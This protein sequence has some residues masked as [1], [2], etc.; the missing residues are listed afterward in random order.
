MEDN[1]KQQRVPEAKK[2]TVK[3]SKQNQPAG[4]AQEKDWLEQLLGTTEQDGIKNIYKFL[5]HPMALVAVLVFILLW[6]L[7]EKKTNSGFSK[8][9]EELKEELAF[10]KK[11]YKKLKKRVDN[12]TEET[13]DSTIEPSGKSMKRPLVVVG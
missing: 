6:S 13:R 12:I 7:K 3:E 9:N 10:M 5:T 4:N 1:Q 2:D 11:K 8:E